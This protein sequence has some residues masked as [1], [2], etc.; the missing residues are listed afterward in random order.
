MEGRTPRGTAA[1]RSSAAEKAVQILAEETAKFERR[2]ADPAALPALQAL[3]ETERLK[4][5]AAAGGD[6]EKA[7]RILV[8]RLLQRPSGALA[9]IEG[10]DASA[11]AKLMERLFG[12]DGSEKD[13]T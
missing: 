1:L 13:R 8:D 6:A 9:A 10:K 11:L 12:L 3:F 4:A 5:L 7:T 2:R